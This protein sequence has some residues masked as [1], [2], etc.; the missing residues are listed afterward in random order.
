MLRAR[1]FI[2][3]FLILLGAVM[4]AFIHLMALYFSYHFSISSSLNPS[5]QIAITVIGVVSLS[6]VTLYYARKYIN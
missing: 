2:L 6:I 3:L 1:D 4:I 5:F